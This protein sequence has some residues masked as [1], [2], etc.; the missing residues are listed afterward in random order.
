ADLHGED[1]EAHGH[2]LT[3][4]EISRSEIFKRE[5]DADGIGLAFLAKAE[6]V[7]RGRPRQKP[8]CGP[9]DERT[10]RQIQGK[11]LHMSSGSRQA[12]VAC[13]EAGGCSS[14]EKRQG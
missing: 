9:H 7:A 2:E 12:R 14:V 3:K 5:S 8:E 6:Q 11:K 4:L 1:I 13:F 10:A